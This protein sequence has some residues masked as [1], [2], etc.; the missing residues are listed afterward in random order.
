MTSGINLGV[1]LELDRHLMCMEQ[2]PVNSIPIARDMQDKVS[3]HWR[4]L[5]SA[6]AHGIC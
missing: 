2:N 3:V 4:W 1:K 5:V 6:A